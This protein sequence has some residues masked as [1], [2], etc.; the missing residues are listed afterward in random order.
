MIKVIVRDRYI[1]I[2]PLW[3]ITSGSVGLPVT[4]DFDETWDGLTRIAVFSGSGE[5]V[6]VALITD[7][8]VV[9]AEVLTTPGGNLMLGVYGRDAYGK[10]VIPTIIG[11]AGFI[12]D[13]TQP[14]EPDPSDPTPE[15]SYQVQQAATEAVRTAIRAEDK[16]DQVLEETAEAREAMEQSEENA[17]ASAQAAA[18]S[19][20]AAAES[21]STANSS[22]IAAAGSATAAGNAQAAAENAQDRAETAM[23]AAEGSA[24][25]ASGSATAAGTA[26]TAA[27]AAQAAAEAA[28]AGADS[29]AAQAV[30]AKADAQ[31]SAE[32]AEDD[33]FSASQSAGY[34][35]T[36]K[37]D[38][39]AAQAAAEAAKTAAQGSA[40]AASDSA[41]DADTAKTAAE[42][43]QAAAE[44]VAASIPE[45]YTDLSNDVS[46]LKSAFNDIHELIAPENIFDKDTM[47]EIGKWYY[48]SNPVGHT[49]SAE[50]ISNVY[51]AIKLP[52]TGL[53]ETITSVT[54][55]QNK[56]IGDVEIKGFYAVDK[57]MVGLTSYDWLSPS[58]SIEN[59]Y[60]IQNI[61]ESAAY[62]LITLLY[63]NEAEGT[64]GYHLSIAVGAQAKD[65]TPYFK[66]YYQLKLPDNSITTQ[67]VV[68]GAITPQKTSFM[69]QKHGENLF[70]INTMLIE[71]EWYTG[72]TVGSAA[73][74]EDLT[75]QHHDTYIAFQIPLWEAEEF[76]FSVASNSNVYIRLA[77]L[78][79]ANGIV[80]SKV[81]SADT[82]VKNGIAISTVP[83]NA[84]AIVGTL[85]YWKTELID[86]NL[87]MMVAYGDEAQPYVPYV[88]PWW[89]APNKAA[90]EALSLAKIKRSAMYI[91]KEDD[92]LELFLKM[93]DAYNEG[94]VDVFFEKSTYTL[95]DAYLYMWNTLNWR[96]SNALPCGNGCRY[97]FNDSTIISN[98]PDNP[99][100]DSN[101]ERSI[102]DCR[103]TANDYEVHD[104]TLINNGGRY[105]IH[106][107]GYNSTTPYC[108]K[109]ENVVMIYNK[110][111]LT[112]DTGAKA[113][114]CGTGFDAGL[115]F[116]GCV[117]Q[118]N[119][120][121]NSARLA[122]HG[123]TTNPDHDT[124]N[125]HLVMKN[126][127]FDEATIY[128]QDDT[129]ETG[130]TLNFFLFDNSFTTAFSDTHVMVIEN[131]NT[132]RE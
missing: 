19:A 20:A 72:L 90:D 66:P 92:D 62:L 88:A 91:H 24:A 124:S 70:D 26:K 82:L 128:V 58:V 79:D 130:S 54:L 22:A 96:W 44:A 78:V 25:A 45:D 38:A 28:R 109:Y 77:G 3:P 129:F 111:A 10:T 40:A 84:T 119:N 113:F 47:V 131:N 80:L 106:D 126:C 14:E 76:F 64:D 7:A 9:P 53:G 11:K 104:V 120:G 37:Y 81:V 105:C 8:C 74:T 117:F 43:A 33:A 46:E 51:A 114:G 73:V 68:N 21:T 108:H 102:L 65:Y 60:T 55:K 101:A 103:N 56:N 32:S 49:I 15:W 71:N 13:G 41:A 122:I 107:E 85:V 93:L 1:N 59:G 4:F 35:N 115:F 110:T 63:Y 27:E 23:D 61:D 29:A 2:I 123:P 100:P 48:S 127:Y 125:L 34:A 67:K 86:K 83:E 31:A 118:H 42:A 6:E 97:Y 57:N 36:A 16:A 98:A 94:N 75:A 69:K 50:T 87:S 52:L 121:Q 18:T 30:A 17:A 39:E 12:Y 116:D 95:S 5:E 99:P 112:P 132:I 89:D